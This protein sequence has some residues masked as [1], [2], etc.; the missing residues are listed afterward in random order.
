M[1]ACAYFDTMGSLTVAGV[2]GTGTWGVPSSVGVLQA[3]TSG[4]RVTSI[5]NEMT[6]SLPPSLMQPAYSRSPGSKKPR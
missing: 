3:P 1:F 4:A 2:V 6:C 5:G